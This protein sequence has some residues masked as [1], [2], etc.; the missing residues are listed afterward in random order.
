M[1]FYYVFG[2]FF[3][4]LLAFLVISV[5]ILLV[6]S[7]C[8]GVSLDSLLDWGDQKASLTCFHCGQQTSASGKTCEH[9]GGELQ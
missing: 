1:W 4:G 3:G 7:W 8:C 5:L 9:C 6:V 2:G